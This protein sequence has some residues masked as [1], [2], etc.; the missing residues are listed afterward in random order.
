M[1]K[2][3]ELTVESILKLD[4]NFERNK[5]SK[6]KNYENCFKYCLENE[7]ENF[8]TRIGS[9]RNGNAFA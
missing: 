9:A 4:V 7:N 5:K 2:S 3:I 6:R 1:A 8:K